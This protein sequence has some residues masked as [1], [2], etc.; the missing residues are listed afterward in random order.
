MNPIFQFQKGKEHILPFVLEMISFYM[1]ITLKA[2]KT[3]KILNVPHQE[4]S[5]KSLCQI[6][7]ILQDPLGAP[8]FA[9]QHSLS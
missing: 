4:A 7:R 5:T 9:S 8:F 2:R 6:K 3:Y 1:Q